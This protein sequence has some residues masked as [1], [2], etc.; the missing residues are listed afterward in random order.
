[1]A[2]GKSKQTQTQ[3]A[4]VDT[5]YLNTDSGPALP[6]APEATH[7]ALKQ[8]RAV[9]DLVDRQHDNV[10]KPAE[11]GASSASTPTG[12]TEDP[13]EKHATTST[14]SR[15]N[16]TNNTGAKSQPAVKE[17]VKTEKRGR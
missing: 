8:A 16:K 5:A 14:L 1:M 17:D 13:S 2:T 10:N 4:A 3:Q 6:P 12:N 11:Y 9:G 15:K 7:P